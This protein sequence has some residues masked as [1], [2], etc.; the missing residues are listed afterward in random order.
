MQRRRAALEGYSI[1]VVEDEAL[2]AIQ[3]RNL[4]KAEGAEVIGPVPSV[5]AA[6]AA[7]AAKRPDAALL[8]VNLR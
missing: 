5:P 4:L 8:D 3:T 2:L 1:L 7:L 6:L